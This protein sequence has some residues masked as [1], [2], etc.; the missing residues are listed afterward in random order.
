[1]HCT[2]WYQKHKNDVP[3][4]GQNTVL[5]SWNALE[6]RF[7]QSICMAIN[8]YLMFNL[9]HGMYMA[10]EYHTNEIIRKNSNC[11]IATKIA[12]LKVDDEIK[13]RRRIFTFKFDLCVTHH[14]S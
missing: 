13:V 4:V 12:T 8:S 3:T 11:T 10:L 6:K 14:V 9:L 1:M 5:T 7:S 2:I